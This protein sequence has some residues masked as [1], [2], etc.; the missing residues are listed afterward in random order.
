MYRQM[1]EHVRR[2]GPKI[3]TDLC[4]QNYDLLGYYRHE[5]CTLEVELKHLLEALEHSRMV[6]RFTEERTFHGSCY[7]SLHLILSQ[8]SAS[9]LCC[10]LYIRIK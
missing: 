3:L 4:A 7:H 5:S 6:N 10:F 9:E 8:H 2:H 1:A